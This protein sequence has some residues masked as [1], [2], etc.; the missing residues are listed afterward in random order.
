MICKSTS[1]WG[2]G[3]CLSSRDLVQ[4]AGGPAF[5]PSTGPPPN[6]HQKE[7]RKYYQPLAITGLSVL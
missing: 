4:C 2:L 1:I 5:I 7:E 6:P 3:M